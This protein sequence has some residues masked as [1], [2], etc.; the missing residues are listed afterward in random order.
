MPRVAFLVMKRPCFASFARQPRLFLRAVWTARKTRATEFYREFRGNRGNRK[1]RIPGMGGGLWIY[2]PRF[3]AAVAA[4]FGR[5]EAGATSRLTG[6]GGRCALQSGQ[7]IRD[8]CWLQSAEERKPPEG[9]W[10]KLGG[11]EPRPEG[12]G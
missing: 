4:A 12:R 6:T 11:R 5:P 1:N 2:F 10:K 8:N 7:D 9:G 3:P